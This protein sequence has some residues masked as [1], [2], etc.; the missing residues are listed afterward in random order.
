MGAPT[1]QDQLGAMALVDDLRHQRIQLQEHMSIAARRELVATRLREYYAAKNIPLEDDLIER[2]VAEYFSK[3]FVYEP[4]ALSGWKKR[5]ADL[6]VARA[7]FGRRLLVASLAAVLGIGGTVGAIGAYSSHQ[8]AKSAQL[9]A[10]AERLTHELAGLAQSFDKMGLPSKD[11][12]NVTRRIDVAKETLA[13]GDVVSAK[14]AVSDLRSLLAFAAMPLSISIVDRQG[15]KSG[16]ERTSNSGGR[17]WYVI[18]EALDGAGNP[19]PVHST[20]VEDGTSRVVSIFGIQVPQ[21]TFEQVK[22]DKQDNG[23]IDDRAIGVKKANTLG[24]DLNSKAN[25]SGS[26]ILE[27]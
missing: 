27:W 24:F 15:V 3:R 25:S 6:Y 4:Y 11:Q 2:G 22:K 8:E 19:V 16:V 23:L 18:A 1:L 9:Q 21:A 26:M 14:A 17:A 7:R 10:D 12:A 13:K 5:I 20:S